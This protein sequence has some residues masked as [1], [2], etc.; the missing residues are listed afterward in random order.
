M[1]YEYHY[2]LLI[3]RAKSRSISGYSEN[4]HIIPKCMGGSDDESNLVKLTAEE[5]YIA[6]LLLVKMYPNSHRLSYA[7]IKM[8]GGNKHQ[9]RSNKLYGWLKREHAIR[10]TLNES[11]KKYYHKDG[12]NIKLHTHEK[13]PEGFIKGRSYSPTSSTSHNRQNDTFKNKGLQSD[14][15]KRRWD[16]ANK[17][18]CDKLNVSNIS[19]ASQLIKKFRANYDRY[20]MKPLIAKYPFMT[21]VTARRLLNMK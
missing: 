6:H 14:L 8:T 12:V 21:P 20:W 2:N 7:A 11:G 1:N 18:L 19:D 17:I 9:K 13:V 16:K 4:H 3:E 5:H 15:A 10:Y